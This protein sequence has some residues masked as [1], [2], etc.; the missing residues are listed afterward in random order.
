MDSEKSADYIYRNIVKEPPTA[1][2]LFAPAG[3]GGLK[4]HDLLN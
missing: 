3:L 2:E 4:V 1:A